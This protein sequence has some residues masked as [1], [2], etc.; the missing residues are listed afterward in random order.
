[1]SLH[2]RQMARSCASQKAHRAVTE[3]HC[4]EKFSQR[5]EDSGSGPWEARVH[6]GP[7]S[8]GGDRTPGHQLATLLLWLPGNKQQIKGLDV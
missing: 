7:P 3:T 5:V 4:Q 1:M 2:T 6:H 8:R